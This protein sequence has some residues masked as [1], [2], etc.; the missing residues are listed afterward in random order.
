[1]TTSAWLKNNSGGH[2]LDTAMWPLTPKEIKTGASNSQGVS[3]TCVAWRQ[4]FNNAYIKIY[5]CNRLTM[6]TPNHNY[7][8]SCF[9]RIGV[10]YSCWGW[11]FAAFVTFSGASADT[12]NFHPTSQT[13]CPQNSKRRNLE[14]LLKQELWQ[15]KNV[16]AKSFQLNLL[17]R[18][19]RWPEPKI[20]LFGFVFSFAPFEEDIANL[21]P[22]L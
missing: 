12:K 9:H 14:S 7:K 16:S 13:F 8:F 5:N 11:L 15:K 21:Q 22:E 2:K 19:F 3:R 17:Q 10:F 6:Q 4:E 20:L 18:T 1:M